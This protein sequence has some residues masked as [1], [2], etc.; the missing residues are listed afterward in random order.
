[1]HSY[2]D[3]LLD[4]DTFCNF[5]E[6]I[7]I[8]LNFRKKNMNDAVQKNFFQMLSLFIEKFP[9]EIFNNKVLEIKYNLITLIFLAINR[10]SLKMMS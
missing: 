3:V 9:K 8:I 7:F 6:V 2:R 5:M 1:M 4:T 10:M